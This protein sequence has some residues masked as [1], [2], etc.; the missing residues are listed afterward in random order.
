MYL[1]G[2]SGS[3]LISNRDES[4]E[5]KHARKPALI[6]QAHLSFLAPIDPEGGGTWIAANEIGEVLILLNGGFVFHQPGL[7]GYRKSRGL[8]VTEMIGS[9]VLE[10]QWSEIELDRIEPFTLVIFS[11]GQLLHAV[12]DGSEKHIFQKDSSQGHIW[13]S[14]TLYEPQAIITKQKVFFEAYAKHS[15]TK[16]LLSYLSDFRD[17]KEGFFIARPGMVD[18]LST[19]IIDLQKTETSMA[20]HDYLDGSESRIQ[21]PI[22]RKVSSQS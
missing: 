4:P 20:Y 8:I 17:S 16:E 1:P 18:T 19:T 2:K 21:I 22:E 11:G 9:G 15:E 14:A 6:A 12:W 10:K 5:R 7:G 3:T 13:S